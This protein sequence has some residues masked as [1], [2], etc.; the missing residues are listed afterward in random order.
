MAELESTN[1][2]TPDEQEPQ[3]ETSKKRTRKKVLPEEIRWVTDLELIEN[4][5]KLRAARV[6][7][8]IARFQPI[9][10]NEL[11][12]LSGLPK[13]TFDK[14]LD[15]LKQD[16]D[17]EKQESSPLHIKPVHYRLKDQEQT[18]ALNKM[19]GIVSDFKYIVE[20]IKHLTLKK[21]KAVN[22]HQFA[23]YMYLMQIYISM[24]YTQKI[25]YMLEDSNPE[26]QYVYADLYRFAERHADYI[27]TT[28]RKIITQEDF[29]RALTHLGILLNV[30]YVDKLLDEFIEMLKNCL[31]V[32]ENER[33]AKSFYATIARAVNEGSSKSFLGDNQDIRYV[34][35][36][37]EKRRNDL[38]ARR[39]RFGT[40]LEQHL[41][42]LQKLGFARLKDL[43]D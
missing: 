1:A 34:I 8:L 30:F 43:I 5:E 32:Q 15:G 3:Q 38:R 25:I 14:I 4:P 26:R 29:D 41:I 39:E 31:E 17:Y 20:T 21:P 18:A 6:L 10:Y 16:L 11:W 35:R 2:L 27:L 40:N 22:Y 28:A 7:A 37:L 9:P 36:K 42:R 19:G 12:R 23:F 33:T 24:I 13:G